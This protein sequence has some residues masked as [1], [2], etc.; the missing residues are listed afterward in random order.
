MQE[1]NRTSDKWQQFSSAEAEFYARRMELLKEPS[2]ADD[3]E[4]ALRDPAERGTAL[5]LLASTRNTA[6]INRVIQPLLESALF[7]HGSIDKAREVL[8]I[9]DRQLVRD[10]IARSIERPTVEDEE[11]YR[12]LAELLVALKE[13]DLLDTLVEHCEKQP[14]ENM[15]EIAQDFRAISASLRKSDMEK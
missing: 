6:M 10:A 8:A 9:A 13:A 7:V 3:L 12:R 15:Q 4:L 1:K 2:L 5:R 11:E 14:S